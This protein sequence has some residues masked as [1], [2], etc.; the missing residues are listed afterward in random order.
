[1]ILLLSLLLL[2]LHCYDTTLIC[3]F[4]F[5]TSYILTHTVT[6]I[7]I[8][9]AGFEFAV[10]NSQ[11]AKRFG[12]LRMS[13][14]NFSNKLQIAKIRHFMNFQSYS[15]NYYIISYFMPI[16]NLLFNNNSRKAVDFNNVH[17]GLI[18]RLDLCASESPRL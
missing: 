5:I 11:F 2:L 4:H 16:K 17:L 7:Y 1:M 12:S 10:R 3:Y 13:F 15:L 6:Y 9:G 18:S 14:C 8:Q